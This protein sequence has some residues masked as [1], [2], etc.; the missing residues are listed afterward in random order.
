MVNTSVSLFHYITY[1]KLEQFIDACFAEDFGDKGDITTDAIFHDQQQ[2][3]A[4]LISKEKGI[5]AGID[6]FLFIITRLD[7]NARITKAK[8]DGDTIEK[9]DQILKIES[10]VKGLLKAER[11]G[12]NFLGRMS[13]QGT[14][15][16]VLDTRKT[17]PG[18]RAFEKYAVKVGGGVNHRIGLFDQVLIKDNHIDNTASIT[19]CIGL[20]RKKWGK[21]YPIIVEARTKEDVTE[22]MQ[23][24][25]DRILLDNMPPALLKEIVSMVNGKIPLEASGNIM[26]D[27][28]REYAETGVDYVSTS[29][30]TA[31][32]ATLDFSLIIC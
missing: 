12:L 19:E 24:T 28:V 7:K 6:V 26:L 31:K 3:N 29:Q 13:I 5:L 25:P 20:I 27:N 32:A 23:C 18:F 15:C 4:Q 17:T 10:S 8:N 21:R 1:S 11:T 2:T 22:A 16:Q 9:G 30:I 14:Q